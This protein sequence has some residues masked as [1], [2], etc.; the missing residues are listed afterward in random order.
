MTY[1]ND[2]QFEVTFKEVTSQHGLL[3]QFDDHHGVILLDV[4]NPF[5]ADDFQ[6]IS[7][8]I[9]P[10]FST[11]GELRGI[12]IH[13]KKFPYWSGVQNRAEYLNFARQN[14]HKFQKAALAMGGFFTQIVARIAKGRVHPQVKTFKYNQIEKAQDWILE[15]K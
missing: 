8:L 10:Y 3:C 5:T 6:N 4:T 7:D 9:D 2:H 12:I 13:A 11:K 1:D 14:H 15:D